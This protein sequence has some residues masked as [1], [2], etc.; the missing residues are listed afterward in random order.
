MHM[1]W[2]DRTFPIIASIA[3]FGNMQKAML[4]ESMEERRPQDQNAP[5]FPSGHILR[6]S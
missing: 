6:Q 2:K 5:D 1:L 3:K 4:Q